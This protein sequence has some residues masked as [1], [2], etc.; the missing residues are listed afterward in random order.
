MQ[1][2]V[3]GDGTSCQAGDEESSRLPRHYT[4]HQLRE[5]WLQFRILSKVQRSWR[6]GSD[7]IHFKEYFA[8][9][10]KVM[11]VK[12]RPATR[13]RWRKY[14]LPVWKTLRDRMLFSPDD[15]VHTT[16]YRDNN[17]R[18]ELSGQACFY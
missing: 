11:E 1:S 8:R 14:Q 12:V 4:L 9:F 3:V 18:A 6:Q 10:P 5:G 16:D 13:F 2:V 7:G 15:W 17:D